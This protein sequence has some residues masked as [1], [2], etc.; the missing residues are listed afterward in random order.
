MPTR[1][2]A[3]GPIRTARA[4]LQPARVPRPHRDRWTT[5]QIVEGGG[6][7]Q[8]GLSRSLSPSEAIPKNY[9]AILTTQNI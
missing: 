5:G 2:H 8:L 4:P 6:T 1:C 7:E 9:I 3:A